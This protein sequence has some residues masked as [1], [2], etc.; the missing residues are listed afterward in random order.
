M[1]STSVLMIRIWA[2]K[3]LLFYAFWVSE[4][5]TGVDFVK[6]VTQLLSFIYFFLLMRLF[7]LRCNA[8]QM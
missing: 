6:S 1:L 5:S 8:F 4:Y 7:I 3:Q 2:T